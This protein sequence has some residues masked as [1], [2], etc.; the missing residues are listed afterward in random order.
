MPFPCFLKPSS[1][2]RALGVRAGGVPTVVPG[3][4]GG[5]LLGRGAGPQNLLEPQGRYLFR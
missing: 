1:G 5:G 3:W 4:G 2:S